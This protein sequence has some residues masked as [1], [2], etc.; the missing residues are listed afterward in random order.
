MTAC[1]A[2]CSCRPMFST[3][4]EACPIRYLSTSC[5]FGSKGLPERAIA[6]A[7]SIRSSPGADQR[8]GD[9]LQLAL[10]A[11][12]RAR[13]RRSSARAASRSRRSITIA[14]LSRARLGHVVAGEQRSRPR[15]PRRRRAPSRSRS[16]AARVRSR[17][18]ANASPIRRTDWSS[19]SR[20]RCSCFICSL[21]CSL[22]LLNSRA[23]PASSSLPSAGTSPLKS[24]P[25]IRFAAAS[26]EA[27]WPCSIAQHEED[28][29]AGQ[30]E[31]AERGSTP[32][33]A[34]G[35]RSPRRPRSS[36]RAASLPGR[37]RAPA[38]RPVPCRS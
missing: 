15:R 20:W 12:D 36:A 32:P 30:G 27:I 17:P 33:S 34:R 21:S 29:D 18:E 16:R 13:P 5:S 19:S 26:I 38:P 2:T 23:R 22:I 37:R 31:E 28:E 6:I 3:E 4:T 9:R 35:R 25:P 14:P 8:V 11:L 1:S 10:A 7:P 24:P